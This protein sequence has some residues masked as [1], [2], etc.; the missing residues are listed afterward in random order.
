MAGDQGASVAA[1]TAAHEALAAALAA[2]GARMGATTGA[3]AATGW[4]GAGGTAMIATAIPYVAALEALSAWVQQSAASAAAI[5]QAY[6]TARA[7]MIQVPI[8]TTN[9]TTQ[10]ALVKTNIVGQNTPAIIGLDTEYFGHFWTNNAAQMGSYEGIVTPILA[11]LGIPPPAAPLTANPAG[12]AGQA[13]AIGEA[14]AHGAASAAMSQSLQ[15][16][17]QAAAAVEPTAAA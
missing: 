3:T 5:E 8:C 16:V 9:R 15:G 7:A 13:A 12:M 6:A 17:N 10:V 11:A 2:E 1:A 14:A 4:I